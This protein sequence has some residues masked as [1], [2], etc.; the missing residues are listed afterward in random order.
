MNQI[1]LSESNPFA[2]QEE[3]VDNDDIDTKNITP[4][5]LKV[6]VKEGED[7]EEKKREAEEN[8]KKSYNTNYLSQFE[9]FETK[10]TPEKVYKKNETTTTTTTNKQKEE[11]ETTN[12]TRTKNETTTKTT[13][14][15]TATTAT[16]KKTN[17][18]T[19]TKITK[20]TRTAWKDEG[21]KSLKEM[22]SLKGMGNQMFKSEKYGPALNIY[23]KALET[24][25]IFLQKP[26]KELME[27][28]KISKEVME[29]IHANG[30]TTIE[31]FFQH[32]NL[33]KIPEIK[34]KYSADAMPINYILEDFKIIVPEIEVTCMRIH[35]NQGTIYLKQDMI[36]KAIIQFKNMLKINENCPSAHL[37]LA[38][39][40]EK[41]KNI[42]LALEHA[43]EAL[44]YDGTNTTL[45]E[46]INRLTTKKD[47]QKTNKKQTVEE[48]ENEEE[49][50]EE[51]SMSKAMIVTLGAVFVSGIIIA[52]QKSKILKWFNKTFKK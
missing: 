45:H 17:T 16:K 52:T 51:Q 20:N 40:Y 24:G 14:K 49:E 2:E 21:E 44:Q 47:K 27:A 42:K 48:G 22:E 39:C 31:T 36:D 25:K 32:S 50:E 9:S 41:E 35:Q 23:E 43:N 1:Q 10:E 34:S 8:L 30:G 11:K 12:N 7:E 18:N 28:Y 26:A 3:I 5:K 46:L 19:T 38:M 15:T 6:N 29:K 13:T 33:S 4:S 37:R